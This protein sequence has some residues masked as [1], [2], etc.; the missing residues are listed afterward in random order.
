MGTKET[1]MVMR[2]TGGK[3]LKTHTPAWLGIVRQLIEKGTYKSHTANL[4]VCQLFSSLNQLLVMH[5]NDSRNCGKFRQNLL[6]NAYN[7]R[8]T[9]LVSQF[10]SCLNHLPVIATIQEIAENSGVKPF[11]KYSGSTPSVATH[12]LV[13]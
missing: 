6:L 7:I 4:L 9:S 10:F 3:A 8:A 12:C 13:K 5:S 1:T 2:A 11:R